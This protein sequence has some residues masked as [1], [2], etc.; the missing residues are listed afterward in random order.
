MTGMCEDDLRRRTLRDNFFI[1]LERLTS[2]LLARDVQG[3]EKEQ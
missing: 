2:T 3:N 1:N